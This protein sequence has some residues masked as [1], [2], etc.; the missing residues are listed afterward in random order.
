MKESEKLAGFLCMFPIVFGIFPVLDII[1]ISILFCKT[2]RIIKCIICAANIKLSE[3][4]CFKRKRL[5][6]NS[7]AEDV[8]SDLMIASLLFRCDGTIFNESAHGFPKHAVHYPDASFNLCCIF[9]WLN[10][11]CTIDLDHCNSWRWIQ[12]VG[13]FLCSMEEITTEAVWQRK[14]R[15]HNLC[16]L[17]MLASGIKAPPPHKIEIDF[18]AEHSDFKL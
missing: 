10:I 11:S 14:W 6:R 17:T 9:M 8:C 5:L 3:W 12:V 16:N 13:G 1:I 2:L 7:R 4:P 18:K 15:H